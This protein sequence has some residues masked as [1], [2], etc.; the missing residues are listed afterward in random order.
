MLAGRLAWNRDDAG[1]GFMRFT[2]HRVGPCTRVYGVCARKKGGG[3]QG[4]ERGQAAVTDTGR[5]SRIRGKPGTR[6][7]SPTAAV[8]SPPRHIR[9]ACTTPK[10]HAHRFSAAASGNAQ[11]HP[12]TRPGLPLEIFTHEPP[13]SH[14]LSF[15]ACA[16]HSPAPKSRGP[17]RDAI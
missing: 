4:R 7:L 14:A 13:G 8:Q 16:C 9:R 2:V 10:A 11:P 15:C 5:Q 1:R 6:R 12:P 17:L 3:S